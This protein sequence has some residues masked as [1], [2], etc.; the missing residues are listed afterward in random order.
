MASASGGRRCAAN[1][2][3]IVNNARMAATNRRGTGRRPERLTAFPAVVSCPADPDSVGPSTEGAMRIYE[4]SPRQDWEEVLRAIGSF[5]DRERL[6]ELLFL[7]LDAGFLLQGLP[8]PE[9]GRVDRIRAARRSAPTS[10]ST[11][12]VGQLIEEAT[13]HRGMATEPHPHV[14]IANYYEQAHAG[15]RRVDRRPASR[16]RSSSSSRKA[17]SSS[18]S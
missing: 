14:E 4:G 10:C 13:T 3:L 11:T 17:R 9:T 12:Q 5:A 1:I 18:A 7:E 8:C 15:D 2:G 16:A 6:K